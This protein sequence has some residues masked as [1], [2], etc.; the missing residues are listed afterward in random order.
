M[1]KSLLVFAALVAV[2]V[3]STAWAEDLNPPPWERGSPGTTYQRWEFGDAS[4]NPPP[5]QDVYNPLAMPVMAIPDTWPNTA[6]MPS[7]LDMGGVWRLESPD[8]IWITIQ[9]YDNE[10]EFKYIWMQITYGAEEGTAPLVLTNPGYTD[11]VV[12]DPI[13]MGEH[14]YVTYDIT[15]MPN[16]PSEVIVIQPDACTAYIDEI[17]VDTICIPEPVTVCFLGLGALALLRKRRP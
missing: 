3:V 2:L 8:D 15:L 14:W 9:N 1:K 17:V 11:I 6:Y 7:Y 16:P 5:E 13:L 4:L 12:S 10:N